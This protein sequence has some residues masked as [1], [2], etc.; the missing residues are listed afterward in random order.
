MG[1]WPLDIRP[2]ATF[3]ASGWVSAKPGE[4]YPSVTDGF[5]LTYEALPGL[6]SGS[7][8]AHV[9]GSAVGREAE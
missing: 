7:G 4:A 9:V 2:V 3:V 8:E 6:A 1:P 5:P